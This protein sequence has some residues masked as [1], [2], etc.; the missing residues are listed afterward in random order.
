MSQ[1]QV[2]F[3]NEED[4]NEISESKVLEKLVNEFDRITPVII[5]MVRGKEIITTEGIFR[6][7]EIGQKGKGMFLNIQI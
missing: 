3:P 5:Q 2:K 1:F 6:M 7:K 4:W